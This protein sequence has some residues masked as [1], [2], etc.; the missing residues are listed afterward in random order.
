MAA[1]AKQEKQ[2]KSI[3]IDLDQFN[4]VDQ[5]QSNKFDRNR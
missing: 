3:R 1:T 4:S 2:G 5:N